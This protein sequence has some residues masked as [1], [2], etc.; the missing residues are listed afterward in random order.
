V[1]VHD[2][3]LVRAILSP[4]KAHTPL[5]IDADAVLSFAVTL[6]RFKSIPRGNPQAGQFGTR[7]Q[8]QQF[9][10]RNSFDVPEPRHDLAAEKRFGIETGER[11]N[12]GA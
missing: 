12:H 4:N 9:A 11:V 8:L 2:F 7:V 1:V 3:N 6:Q 5:V 10:T